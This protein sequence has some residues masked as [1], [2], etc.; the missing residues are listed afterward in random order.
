MRMERVTM[1]PPL[2]KAACLEL[3]WDMQIQPICLPA[4]SGATEQHAASCTHPLTYA[5]CRRLEGSSLVS[6]SHTCLRKRVSVCA[7]VQSFDCPRD[8][9]T[10]SILLPTVFRS[11]FSFPLLQH[12]FVLFSLPLFLSPPFSATTFPSALPHVC[13]LWLV[14]ELREC[15]GE[16]L[17]MLQLFGLHASVR[18]H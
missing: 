17:L 14:S 9:L 6:R 15:W 8:T 2:C 7:N 18:A 13:R 3:G 16:M 1:S 10:L 5:Q 4:P 12:T 11:P